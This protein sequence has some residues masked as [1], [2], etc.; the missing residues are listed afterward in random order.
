[1]EQKVTSRSAF[2]GYWRQRKE[3]TMLLVGD[4]GQV[5]V[6]KGYRTWCAIIAGLLLASLLCATL[7]IFALQRSRARHAD[8]AVALDQAR[9]ELSDLRSE[10]EVLLARTM[11]AESR[12]ATNSPEKSDPATA[13]PSPTAEPLMVPGPKVSIEGFSATRGDGGRI[14]VRF[15]L[16]NTGDIAPP[17]NGFTFV[18][19]KSAEGGAELV[20]VL[21]TVQLVDGKPVETRRG[22]SFSISRFNTVRFNERLKADL[23][24]FGSATVLVFGEKGELL[25]EQTFKL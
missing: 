8:Q 20:E 1:M 15:R 12:I 2:T 4:H 23:G 14:Q 5:A 21:P 6:L 3:W 16:I 10:N 19:F 13:S 24:S 11:L 7:A 18:V 22:R 9:Q 17:L 25:R